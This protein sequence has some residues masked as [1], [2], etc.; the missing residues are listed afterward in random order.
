MTKAEKLDLIIKVRQQKNDMVTS[1]KITLDQLRKLNNDLDTL[2]SLL[3]NNNP[4]GNDL[5]L[6]KEVKNKY[7]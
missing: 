6:L 5:K 2:T 1:G 7:K 3:N 4:A